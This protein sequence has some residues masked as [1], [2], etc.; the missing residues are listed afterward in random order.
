M[1][2]MLRGKSIGDE[3]GDGRSDCGTQVVGANVPLERPQAARAL[4][5]AIAFERPVE[6][7]DLRVGRTGAVIFAELGQPGGDVIPPVSK[8]EV[9]PR[10]GKSLA[11]AVAHR[12]I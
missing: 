1:S 7:K 5:G 11:D 4:G 12:G 3:R 9:E 6:V 10:G 2:R 8:G